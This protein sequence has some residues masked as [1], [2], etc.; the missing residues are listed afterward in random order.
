[1]NRT[2]SIRIK[3]IDIAFL[4]ENRAAIVLLILSVIAML[5]GTLSLKNERITSL[6]AEEFKNFVGERTNATFFKAF[7]SSVIHT[8]KLPLISFL[9][10]TSVLGTVISPSVLLF[11]AFRYGYISGY[12][13]SV[14]GLSGIV[15]NLFVLILPYLIL[16]FSLLVSARECIDFSKLIAS[17]CIRQT[18]PQNLYNSFHTFCVR[19]LVLLFPIVLS[20]LADVSLFNI[21]EKY[22]NF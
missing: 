18:R 5:C 15:F 13:Y 3:G 10:G 14:F 17:L 9:C 12:V 19:H 16:L 4:K 1:M 22:F 11:A 8:L 7:V 21:F 6:A 20:A 2:A